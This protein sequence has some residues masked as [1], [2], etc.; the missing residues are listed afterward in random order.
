MFKFSKIFILLIIALLLF[1]KSIAIYYY[2]K[3]FSK[4]IE[5]EFTYNTMNIDYSG[6]I[7]VTDLKIKN[8]SRYYYQNIFEANK[9]TL[10]LDI[11]SLLFSKLVL[12]NK[13]V[14]DRPNFFLEIN[15]IKW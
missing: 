4:W 10:N 1:H 13:L 9:V 7:E 15:R 14:I 6:K 3:K 12:I 8:S 2:S 5:R 11:K